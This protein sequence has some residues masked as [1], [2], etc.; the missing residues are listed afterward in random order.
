[1]F[2]VSSDGAALDSLAPAAGSSW[3]CHRVRWWTN[4]SECMQSVRGSALP[5]WSI[6]L[7]AASAR[8]CGFLPATLGYQSQRG[9]RSY[10][11]LLLPKLQYPPPRMTIT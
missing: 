8:T 7:V 10:S 9:H 2:M 11:P 6:G 3:R 1:V 5:D 4:P